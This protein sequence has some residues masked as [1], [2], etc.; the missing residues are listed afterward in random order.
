MPTRPSERRGLSKAQRG[1]FLGALIGW[2]FDYYEVF[3]M[4]LLVIPIAQEFGL[5]TA[6]VGTLFALQLL[7]MAV[8]GVGFGF[9]AD[10]IGRKKVLILTI[11]IFSIGTMARGI[12]P[13]Y[14]V[15][16]LLTAISA[17]GIGGEYGVGQ[18]LVSESV[19]SDKRGFYSA[20]LYGGIYIGILMG[21]VVGGYLTPVIGWRWTFV[22]SGLPVLLALWVRRHTPES[23]VWTE[24]NAAGTTAVERSPRRFRVSPLAGVWLLC[25]LA[26]GLQFFAYYGL[27][28]FLPTY[29]VSQ[30][31]SVAGA[32]LWL[33]FTAVAG[34]VGCALTAALSDRIGRRATLSIVA[35]IACVAGIWLALTWD[36]LF[37]GNWILVP[38]FLLFVG[39]NGAAVF[40]A[41]F[42]ELFPAA[43][44]ATGVSSA[45]QVGRGLSFFPPLLAAAL[46]PSFGYQPVVY[47][48]AGLF[49]V[50]ALVAWAFR[51]TRNFELG[52]TA[53]ATS[54]D[55]Q[56]SPAS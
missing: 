21:A 14:E 8:G 19:A 51:D 4:T 35:G 22:L 10:R 31:S 55:S 26:A 46:I 27:A 1:A 6:Q 13:N 47:I 32:S 56:S 11:L 33:V 5:S 45:L 48:S 42:S 44:R 15:L 50:L 20:V 52:E 29:L 18:T 17:I 9:L 37:T 30:G 41:L 39:S 49:G 53:R 54:T 12:A 40:G 36:Q 23:A 24:S 16:V 7:F 43:V 3:L 38:F 34:S 25:V 2:I 28:T